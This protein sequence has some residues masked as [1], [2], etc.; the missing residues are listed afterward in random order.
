MAEERTL[1]ILKPDAMH[2]GLAGKI[3]A[4]FEDKGYRIAGA[5]LTQIPRE[6]A[7][8]HYGEHKG[9]PFY[10][11]LVNFM[12]QSPVLLMCLE[13]PRVISVARKMMGATFAYKAEPG[14][15]RGDF[16]SSK[17]LNL[18]HGSDSPASAERELALFFKPG[19]ICDWTPITTPWVV[20]DEDA[21]AKSD[22]A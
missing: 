10:D 9:K 13:G 11:G 17:G 22:D 5:K 18:I 3:I 12:T 16:G 20:G 7:E 14:T 21:G 2:R 4:R 15:I 8:T 19:E 6:T 1:I